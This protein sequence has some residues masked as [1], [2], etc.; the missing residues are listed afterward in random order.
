MSY[1][2]VAPSVFDPPHLLPQVLRHI[3]DIG[4]P[5]AAKETARLDP[6]E[7]APRAPIVMDGLLPAERLYDIFRPHLQIACLCVFKSTGWAEWPLLARKFLRAFDIP[8][9]LDD[10]LLGQGW[11]QCMHSVLQKAITP[12]VVTAVFH[13]LWLSMGGLGERSALCGRG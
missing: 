3:L 6:L 12:F 2:R 10:V 9:D 13:A 5:D 4:C 7:C 1:Q 11:E 8:L